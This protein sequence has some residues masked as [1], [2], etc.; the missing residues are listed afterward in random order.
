MA[1]G[2]IFGKL[3]GTKVGNPQITRIAQ[4]LKL[5]KR[6]YEARGIMASRPACSSFA[7]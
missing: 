6:L 5:I 3:D 7:F 2:E 4:N 1:A